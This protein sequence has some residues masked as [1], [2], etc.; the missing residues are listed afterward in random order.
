MLSE[1]LAETSSRFG[2]SPLVVTPTSSIT[3]SE[4]RTRSELVARQLSRLGIGRG[5]R[6]ALMMP[7]GVAW[8]VGAV[9]A[10]RVGAL[11]AGISP[12]ASPPE[13][14][15]MIELLNPTALLDSGSASSDH[16]TFLVSRQGL[17]APGSRTPVEQRDVPAH[18]RGPDRPFAV[19]FTSGT[20][21]APKAALFHDSHAQAVERIDLGPEW[22]NIWGGGPAMIS[23]TQFAHVGFVLKFGWYMRLGSTMH[24]M[25][26]WSATDA[27]DLVA[28]N[29]MSALGVVAPQ[30]ALILRSPELSQRDLSALK[31]VI[32]GGAT[33]PAA[34]ISEACDR[35]G[36][37]YSIRWSS[38][39]SG[40]VGLSLDIPDSDSIVEGIGTPRPGV[41]ARVADGAG[42]LVAD[43]QEGELQ[44]RSQ[45]MMTEY[46]DN[47]AATAAAFTTDG[48]QRTGDLAL[49][50][51]LGNYVLRGRGGDMYIRGGYNVHPAEVE[52]VLANH[53]AVSAIAIAP[54]KDPV[55]GEVGVAMVVTLGNSAPTLEDLRSFGADHLSKHKLPERIEYVSELPLTDAQ[56]LDRRRLTEMLNGPTN[57][58]LPASDGEPKS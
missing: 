26:R 31:L 5:D 52:T 36:V 37:T 18:D 39:E 7:S 12:I 6:V 50:N 10:D 48:W 38:T 49:R 19:C 21:G 25:D 8:V 27:I 22:A 20:T 41:E 53:H 29:Q 3:H 47:P 45:A 23:S 43:G 30:L 13:R 2:S 17:T 4:L 9:A 44:V 33:S 57:T 54:S 35:L 51:E 14:A 32:A 28:T 56:K 40:G 34:L 24:V 16:E 58:A 11:F 15:A 1:T 55:M 46:L 42:S